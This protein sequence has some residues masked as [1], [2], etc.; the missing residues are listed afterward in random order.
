MSKYMLFS[1]RVTNCLFLLLTVSAV[2]FG[3]S[4]SST[5]PS[6]VNVPVVKI[7]TLHPASFA[8]T[9]TIPGKISITFISVFWHGSISNMPLTNILRALVNLSQA[10]NFNLRILQVLQH[11][12]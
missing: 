7:D 6:P 4:K 2:F 1:L 8:Q 11:Y 9:V 3:C 10:L 12:L 5:S